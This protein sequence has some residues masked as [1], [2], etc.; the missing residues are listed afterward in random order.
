MANIHV[1]ARPLS[2]ANAPYHQRQLFSL[3]ST[4]IEPC[5]GV[6]PAAQRHQLIVAS[7]LQWRAIEPS[8][9][10]GGWFY[11][12]EPAALRTFANCLLLSAP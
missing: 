9:G 2:F 3:L 5:D 8:D 6:T 10:R 11:L 7:D 1:N 12:A 4:L